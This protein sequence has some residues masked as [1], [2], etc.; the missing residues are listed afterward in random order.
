MTALKL[1]PMLL[2]FLFAPALANTPVNPNPDDPY[3]PV[4]VITRG[5]SKGK[6]VDVS[7]RRS[8]KILSTDNQ[9]ETITMANFMHNG[10]FHIATIPLNGVQDVISQIDYANSGFPAGHIETRI[11]FK[12]DM[13]I[14][15]R[16]QLISEQ[17]QPAVAIR[18]MVLSFE[19][20]KDET[21]AGALLKGFANYYNIA[22]RFVSMR[23]KHHEFVDVVHETVKQWVLK[24]ND[25][26][27]KSLIT[28]AIHMSDQKGIST[29]YNTWTNN[30]DIEFVRLL[31][32]S[33]PQ[34]PWRRILDDATSL[35]AH[36]PVWFRS[37]M[38]SRGLLGKQ[39]PSV[40]KDPSEDLNEYP[41][42]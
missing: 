27:K 21:G 26:Q 20:I 12:P 16:P 40:G 41:V 5:P 39:L 42:N 36:Y 13:P 3:T 35:G 33:V 4:Y 2:L 32:L 25:Q 18:D 14:I 23:D 38:R 10:K 8:I 9:K 24:L 30:C 6:T 17:N 28:N 37:S 1:L 31:D 11:R 19:A 15:L 22:Y 29:F 7:I 34:S